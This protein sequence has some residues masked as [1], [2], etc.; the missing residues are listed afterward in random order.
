M[1]FIDL[2]EKGL[3]IKAKAD[4]KQIHSFLSRSKKDLA[5]A[6]QNINTDEEWAYAIAYNAMLRAARALLMASGYRPKGKDQHKTLVLIAEK[7]LGNRYRELTRDFD[8]MRRKRH[9]FIYAP[10]QPIPK[11]ESETALVSA[12]SLSIVLLGLSK[13]STRKKRLRPRISFGAQNP[14]QPEQFYG[15]GH[16]EP[17]KSAFGRVVFA[18]QPWIAR[19][20]LSSFR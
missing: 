16:G 7:A 6:R 15:G 20:S 1:E 4:F 3:L 9:E 10:N 2:E 14:S 11:F 17:E 19:R 13:K 18:P 5:T 8:R 12:E